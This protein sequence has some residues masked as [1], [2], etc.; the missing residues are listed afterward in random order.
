M[1]FVLY[2]VAESSHSYLFYSLISF[3][4]NEWYFVFV[5]NER[6]LSGG[7]SIKRIK[8]DDRN[9]KLRKLRSDIVI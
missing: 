4:I 2:I 8:I 7:L 6:L 9:V 5:Q 1:Q 3:F